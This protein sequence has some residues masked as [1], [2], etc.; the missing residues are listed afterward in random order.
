M[1]R[2]ERDLRR[3]A[4]TDGLPVPLWDRGPGGST[5][6]VAEHWKTYDLRRVLEDD[7][8]ELG[9]KLRGKLHIWVGEADDYFLNNAVHL[10][11]D[12]LKDARPA[13]R[14]KIIYAMGKDHFWRGL[15]PREML[16]EMAAQ[17]ERGKEEKKARE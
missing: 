17:V 12:F 16:D 9:P 10:L 5:A 6:T 14:G 2:L 11:D 1:G 3:R 8:A 4:A 15:T 7:W 13:Y